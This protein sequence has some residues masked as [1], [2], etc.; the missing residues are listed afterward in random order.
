MRYI[1]LNAD[2]ARQI[3]VDKEE[4][5]YL[6]HVT[7]V[8]LED[9][10]TMIA[11]YPKGHGRGGIIQK[12]SYDGGLTWTA[13]MPLPDSFETSMEVPTIYRTYDKDGNKRL[14]L[15]SGLYP[16]R[17]AVSQDDGY[18]WSDLKTVIDYNGI[19]AMGDCIPLSTPG[20]YLA[21]YH[22]EGTAR[23]GDENDWFTF[24][25][26][27][28]G[29]K[30]KIVRYLQNKAEDGSYGER[31]VDYQSGDPEVA[32]ENGE[33]I[34]ETK[35]HARNMGDFHLNKTISTDGGL[36]WSQPQTV[37]RNTEIHLCEPGMIRLDDGS[38][39]I[40][41]RENKRVKHSHIMFS[42]DEG[43]TFTAPVELPEAL[44]GDRHTCRRLRDGR[45]VITFRNMPVKSDEN[46][47]DWCMWVGTDADLRNQ[48]DGQY[49]FR[50]K[51][52]H[53]TNWCGDC[54]YP[55][56]QILPDDTIVAITYGHWVE[57]EDGKNQPYIL[58]VRL[59]L[60]E[61]DE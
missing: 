42:Y 59:N 41:L 44:T 35:I 3:V 16:I 9:N 27:T 45:I 40:L 15:F 2:T 1:D 5:Q 21:M 17:M 24:Y 32:E 52:N 46:Q 43:E 55:G 6:G 47:G 57:W 29:E 49:K 8:L 61:F 60:K 56:L 13:R 36:S 25:R 14:I 33:L 30:K 38:I 37:Y 48:T 26:Y 53:K 12:M 10:K 39:A 22:D 51:K 7:T 58:E 18:T 50:L 20:K 54:G 23:A 28:D 11:V 34:Y 19:V 31:K 4:G